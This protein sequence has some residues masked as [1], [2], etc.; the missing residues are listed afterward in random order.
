METRG[1]RGGGAQPGAPGGETP[2]FAPA[3]HLAAL[4][5]HAPDLRVHTVLADVRSVPDLAALE[6]AVEAPVRRLV[7]ADIA[8]DDGSP[9]HDPVKLAAAYAAVMADP[10]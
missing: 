4:L 2:G 7:V 3:D 10:A 8:A 6:D 5:E 1:R 9:R